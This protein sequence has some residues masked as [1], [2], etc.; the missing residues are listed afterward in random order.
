MT[1]RAWGPFIDGKPVK[2]SGKPSSLVN[3]ATEAVFTEVSPAE[4]AEVDAAAHGALKAFT[5]GWRDL[6][7]G[8][9]A[10]ALFTLARLIR[11]K[12]EEL[13]Q[14]ETACVGKPIMESRDEADTAGGVFEY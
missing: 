4:A 11:E 5:G 9:R 7:P 3:P 6:A 13:A 2:T 14:L 1:S 10:A 12:T 8:K